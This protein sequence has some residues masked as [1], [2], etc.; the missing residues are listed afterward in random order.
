MSV[1]LCLVLSLP[2][3]LLA[4]LHIVPSK[5]HTEAVGGATTLGEVTDPWGHAGAGPLGWG[6]VDGGTV[7]VVV[8]VEGVVRDVAAEV[9]MF[10]DAGTLFPC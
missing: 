1:F 3:I 9:L 4:T 7:V 6:V 10:V 8:V 5:E 2:C